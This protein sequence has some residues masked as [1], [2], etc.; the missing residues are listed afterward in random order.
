MLESFVLWNRETILAR[1]RARAL[2][3]LPPVANDAEL[4]NGI[5]MFLSQLGEA[6][7]V[8]KTGH[9]PGH[10]E[11]KQT[12]ARH[13]GELYLQGLTPRQ[14]VHDYG[15]ICQTITE[16][17]EQ[18]HVPID[19]SEFRV[20]NLCLDDAIAEAVTEFANQRERE[21]LK[22]SAERLGMLA[23]EVRNLAGTALMSFDVIRHGRAS[24]ESNTGAILRRSLLS[25]RDLVDLS[26]ADVRLDAG[27]LTPQLVPLRL[28]MAEVGAS[29]RMHA[30]ARGIQFS[31][32]S[33]AD[34]AFIRCDPNI[35]AAILANLLQNAFKFCRKQGKVS[36]GTRTTADR[37]FFDIQD[38]CGGLPPGMAE[39]LFQPFEQRSLDRTGLGLGLSFCRKAARA[40]LGDI[41]VSNLP[42]EGCIF[43]LE[44][45][46]VTS[47]PSCRGAGRAGVM[48][49][50]RS[51]DELARP[52][53]DNSFYDA[54]RR[55]LLIVA[56]R[57]RA[58]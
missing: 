15:E 20:L 55:K 29:A 49:G 44:L 13:G 22:Q 11:L 21:V 39:E 57:G 1:A 27:A 33:S 35:V 2:P 12:A 17:A 6:L 45:P 4:A 56:A 46:R 5:P 53:P 18:Q 32:T 3:S 16:L 38:E 48:S 34:A 9:L 42:G 7:R 36:L 25:L 30:Q 50:W 58:L 31:E 40:M 54:S 41:R 52:R 28:L 10:D 23:H 24:P 19:G 51:P 26:L 43:T 37:V 47:P 8:A 14:V